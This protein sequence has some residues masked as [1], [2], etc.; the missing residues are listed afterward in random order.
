[1][2]DQEI[3]PGLEQQPE[4]VVQTAEEREQ[5]RRLEL[6]KRHELII[7]EPEQV[8]LEL[9]DGAHLKLIL[10]EEEH[11]DISVKQG[12]PLTAPNQYMAVLNKEN[13]EIGMIPDSSLLE[14]ASQAALAHYFGT[15]Y[16]EVRILKVLT[17]RSTFGIT[18]WKMTTD[19]GERTA[20]IRDRSDIRKLPPDRLLFTDIEG[21]RYLV[22]DYARLDARSQ[23]L[24]EEYT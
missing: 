21:M 19:R 3:E 14:E 12:F 9:V 16:Y 7:L 20:V 6:A 5:A 10:G 17:V 18:T 1:M 15:A 24:I 23:M 8:R 11:E 22:D 13:K 4:E 2:A